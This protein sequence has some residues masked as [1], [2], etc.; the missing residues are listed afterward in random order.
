MEIWKAVTH[1]VGQVFLRVP[2]IP[3]AGRS[4]A[5]V[6]IGDENVCRGGSQDPTRIYRVVL[7]RLVD[8]VHEVPSRF[9]GVDSGSADLIG[10]LPFHGLGNSLSSGRRAVD[11][12]NGQA[13]EVRQKHHGL[14]SCAVQDEIQIRHLDAGQ[15][16][17]V[18]FLLERVGDVLGVEAHQ[19]ANPVQVGLCPE[20][21]DRRG[22]DIVQQAGPAVTK[23]VG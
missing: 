20:N 6:R 18:L 11:R 2:E 14:S 15:V 21:G 9:H 5:R 23:H 8:V 22:P 10:E 17:E 3:K 16:E 4:R 12:I 1:G 13:S 19:H 7:D